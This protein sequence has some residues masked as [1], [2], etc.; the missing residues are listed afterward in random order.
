M[1]PREAGQLPVPDHDA[2]RRAWKILAPQRDSLDSKLR[3]GLWT[4]VVGR[5]D[6]VLLRDVLGLAAGEVDTIWRAAQALRRRRIG[7]EDED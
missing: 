1:E 5:V 3:D 4:H 7:R 2:L 6:E